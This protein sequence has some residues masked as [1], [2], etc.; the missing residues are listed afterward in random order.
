MGYAWSCWLYSKT[1]ECLY[2]QTHPPTTKTT[3]T[4]PSLNPRPRT[5]FGLGTIGSFS[6]SPRGSSPP[7][8]VPFQGCYCWMATPN[9][10]RRKP[11]APP[12]ARCSWFGGSSPPLLWLG[13]GPDPLKN[14]LPAGFAIS[15]LETTLKNWRNPESP[16][17]NTWQ[18]LGLILSCNGWCLWWTPSRPN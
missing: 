7:A 18:S 4:T 10:W 17:D 1:H 12:R 14:I 9:S 13:L 3:K 8:R 16:R 6:N 2:I 5:L 15:S 11:P